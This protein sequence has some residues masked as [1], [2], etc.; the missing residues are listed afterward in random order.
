LERQ[1]IDK[2][3]PTNCGFEERKEI[4]RNLAFGQFRLGFER[5]V[6]QQMIPGAQCRAL[7]LIVS[8]TMLAV[9]ARPQ[10]D[11]D[12]IKSEYI[13][14]NAQ[15]QEHLVFDWWIDSD[16]KSPELLA[17]QWSLAGRW[18]A[19]WLDA[20]P[21]DGLTGPQNAFA[22]LAPEANA[23]ECLQLDRDVF[24]AAAP[25]NIGNVF[26]VAKNAGHYQLSWSTAQ[27]QEAK[28]DQAALLA[29]WRPENA[30][31]GGRGPYLAASGNDGSVLP[32]I[33]LLPRDA[34]GRPRFY[35]DG[36]YAQSAGGTA[37]AQI[38]VW[39][40]DGT[41]ARPLI[42]RA[43]TLMIDQQVGT[44]VE[45]DLLKVQQKKFFHTF[46][47]C[48]ACEE[49]QTDWTVRLTPTGVQD[50]GEKSVVPE[51]DTVD[52]LFYRVIRHESATESAESRVIKSAERIV[53]EV[54]AGQ[55][56]KDWAKFPSLG[57]MGTWKTRVGAGFT[58][59]CLALDDAGTNLFTL[60]S[61]HEK[62][63]IADLK[64]TKQSC[65][66]WSAAAVQ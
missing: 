60:K 36:T 17:R 20:H 64:E 2:R 24:L 22:E 6:G 18:L 42:A 9:P 5:L 11:A 66:D 46:F 26:I 63:Y 23:P 55:S 49:R 19:A 62:F 41:T 57:M 50:L 3:N 38:S 14:I 43:Y 27:P 29:A 25:G 54:R 13:S 4:E 53:A 45:G 8:L 16:P 34:N 59:L 37:G 65:E 56:A 40:W 12:H 51:L 31:H 32:R 48:G 33:G 58:V 35:I 39:L 44:R 47:A 7:L 30:R 21:L 1:D 10:M 28:G 61:V 52:E 15:L